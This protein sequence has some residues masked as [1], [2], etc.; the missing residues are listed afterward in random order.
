VTSVDRTGLLLAAVA[1]GAVAMPLKEP[2]PLAGTAEQ[3][4]PKGV[5]MA[6]SAVAE[7]VADEVME[8]DV[9]VLA[10]AIGV[11]VEDEAAAPED[12]LGVEVEPHAARPIG[13]AARRATK[14]VVRRAFMSVFLLSPKGIEWVWW[15]C[16]V[17]SVLLD[18]RCSG[19]V[20]SRIGRSANGFGHETSTTTCWM[21]LDPSGNGVARWSVWT[22]P[23]RS[24]ARTAR[25]CWP[26]VAFQ[27]RYHWRQ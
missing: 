9:L 27:G 4:G 1:T 14:A 24:V 21:P 6:L 16:G 26:E 13:S 15:W 12:V 8:P 25:V 2:A 23:V 19:Q 5:P 20:E 7:P 17:L 18:E 22:A 11:D 10:D 3:P